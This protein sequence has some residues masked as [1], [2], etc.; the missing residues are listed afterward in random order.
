MGA[1]RHDA[2]EDT[3]DRKMAQEQVIEKGAGGG[4]E[5]C[6]K[7]TPK[8][9]FL[10]GNRGFR[11]NPKSDYLRA[12]FMQFYSGTETKYCGCALMY[13]TP[14]SFQIHCNSQPQYAGPSV[15]AV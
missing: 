4:R 10:S 1:G 13:V 6:K 5:R 15:E 8:S 3:E 14:T 7:N 11:I 2:R 9:L 12:G